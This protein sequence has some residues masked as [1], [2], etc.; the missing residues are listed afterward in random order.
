MCFG[1]VKIEALYCEW[2]AKGPMEIRLSWPE[3]CVVDGCST[4]ANQPPFIEF[5]PPYEH[6]RYLHD[7]A[8]S[9]VPPVDSQVLLHIVEA[10]MLH[11]CE[12]GRPTGES[13]AG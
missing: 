5:G 10:A 12:S 4:A 6:T 2:F 11:A 9:H 13:F 1:E 7:P 3:K 8:L